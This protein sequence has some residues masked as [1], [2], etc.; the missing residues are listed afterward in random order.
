MNRCA[1]GDRRREL[2]T[3]VGEKKRKRSGMRNLGLWR[4]GRRGS[5]WKY[6]VCMG[7]EDDLLFEEM[8]CD[9]ETLGLV[10]E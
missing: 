4:V 9:E 7:E 2:V 1:H 5:S 6:S 3:G 8:W 10:F